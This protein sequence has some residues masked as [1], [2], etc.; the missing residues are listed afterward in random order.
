MDD[1]LDVQL[2]KYEPLSF[3]YAETY[4]LQNTKYGCKYIAAVSQIT[5]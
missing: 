1:I 2:P 5:C 3:T 4:F